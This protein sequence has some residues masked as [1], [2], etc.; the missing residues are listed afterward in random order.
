MT[1]S[2]KQFCGQCVNFED[3]WCNAPVP[4]RSLNDAAKR[5]AVSVTTEATDCPCFTPREEPEH[6]G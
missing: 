6:D 2:D 3:E 1:A 5:I 4:W